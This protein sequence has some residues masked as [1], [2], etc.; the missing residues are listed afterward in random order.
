[1]ENSNVRDMDKSLK[2][3]IYSFYKKEYEGMIGN[4]KD[5]TNELEEYLKDKGFDLGCVVQYR[6]TQ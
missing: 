4:A 6:K 1:M 5:F 3:A 2:D